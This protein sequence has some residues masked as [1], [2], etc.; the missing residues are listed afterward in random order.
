[1]KFIG[2]SGCGKFSQYESSTMWLDS[3]NCWIQFWK[4]CARG[5]IWSC[6]VSR[7]HL[8]GCHHTQAAWACTCAP[9]TTLFAEELPGYHPVQVNSHPCQ[10]FCHRQH[11]YYFERVQFLSYI[12]HYHSNTLIAHSTNQEADVYACT[13]EITRGWELCIYHFLI[14]A[15]LVYNCILLWGYKWVYWPVFPALSDKSDGEPKHL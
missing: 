14:K 4:S 7:Y 1:M 15:H 11:H 8:L 2:V 13:F 3:L 10:H 6:V 9:I 5:A 12:L